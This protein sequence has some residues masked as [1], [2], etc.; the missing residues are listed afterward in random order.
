[1]EVSELLPLDNELEL[2]TL[3]IARLVKKGCGNRKPDCVAL[4][5]F[6][7]IGY[8]MNYRDDHYKL[9]SFYVTITTPIMPGSS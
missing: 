2:A 7:A 6:S 8:G 9:P 3:D 1:M 4:S 5:G